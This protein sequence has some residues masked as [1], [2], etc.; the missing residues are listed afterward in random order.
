MSRLVSHFSAAFLVVAVVLSTVSMASAAFVIAPLP[1]GCTDINCNGT[2]SPCAGG[3]CDEDGTV[4]GK[5]WC[6]TDV[7][8]PTKC[9]CNVF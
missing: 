4:V 2:P 9:T 7:T 6:V 3:G 8:K 5:C 1:A